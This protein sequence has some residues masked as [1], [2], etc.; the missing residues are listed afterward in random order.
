MY[1]VCAAVAALCLL[2]SVYAECLIKLLPIRKEDFDSHGFLSIYGQVLDCRP[3][4]CVRE[5]KLEV[6]I[7]RG[8]ECKREIVP[9]E[10]GVNCHTAGGV[11]LAKWKPCKMEAG[12]KAIVVLTEMDGHKPHSCEILIPNCIWECKQIRESCRRESCD[13]G[14][15]SKSCSKPS[16]S[17]VHNKLARKSVCQMEIPAVAKKSCHEP[18]TSKSS[19]S[20]AKKHE[21]ACR[22]ETS[23]ESGIEALESNSQDYWPDI[24]KAN[25][26]PMASCSKRQSVRPSCNTTPKIT[27][28]PPEMEAAK[29]H[30]PKIEKKKETKRMGK[31]DKSRK[32]HSCSGAFSQAEGLIKSLAA[33]LLLVALAA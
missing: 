12:A 8:R 13:S 25:T 1:C 32:R 11:L 33:G 16:A 24:S 18:K 4:R 28:C 19:H 20:F 9:I 30:Q 2:S 31:C 14:V 7:T 15:S 23:S 26:K 3:E 21:G 10:K 6:V 29:K 22:N 17:T 27:A 5:R